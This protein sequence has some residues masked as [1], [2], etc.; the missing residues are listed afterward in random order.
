MKIESIQTGLYR[1]VTGRK[2]LFMLG[3]LAMGEMSTTQRQQWL[4]LF[5]TASLDN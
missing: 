1:I 2:S 5:G 3:S 4:D